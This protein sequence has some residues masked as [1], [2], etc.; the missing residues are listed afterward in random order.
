MKHLS[1]ILLFIFTRCSYAL[2]MP[3]PEFEKEIKIVAEKPDI[4]K[5]RVIVY[6]IMNYSFSSKGSVLIHVPEP[7][8]ACDRFLFGIN[9][10]VR[11]NRIMHNK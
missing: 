2:R 11:P 6:E 3:V 7:P 9:L 4:Y 5:I 8:R 10:G 1:V